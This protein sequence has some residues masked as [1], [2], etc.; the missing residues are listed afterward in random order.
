[1]ASPGTPD[2]IPNDDPPGSPGEEPGIPDVPGDPIPGMGGFDGNNSLFSN[3]QPFPTTLALQ[4][5]LFILKFDFIDEDMA[6]E[7]YEQAMRY[8]H[9]KINDCMQK[10]AIQLVNLKIL[11]DTKLTVGDPRERHDWQNKLTIVQ[12]ATLIVQYFCP[13]G[14]GD[15]TLAESFSKIP[16]HYRL[17]DHDLENATFMRHIDLVSNYERAKGPLT[18]AQH[19]ELIQIFEKRLGKGSQIQQDYFKAKALF[20]P[21]PHTWMKAMLR[22]GEVLNTARQMFATIKSYGNP[23]VPY[24]HPYGS[25]PPELKGKSK[26]K[27]TVASVSSASSTAMVRDPSTYSAVPQVHSKGLGI[28]EPAPVP[29]VPLVRNCRSCGEEGHLLNDCPV[30][31]YNDT[32]NDHNVEWVDSTVGRKWAAVGFSTWQEPFI[33]PGYETR[34]Q[35]YAPGSKPFL[36]CNSNKRVPNSHGSTSDSTSADQGQGYQGKHGQ[37]NQNQGKGVKFAK[38]KTNPGRGGLRFNHPQGKYDPPTNQGE[39]LVP[40]DV[41]YTFDVDSS[42]DV[43]SFIPIREEFLHNPS[44]LPSTHLNVTVIVQDKDKEGPAKELRAVGKAVLDTAN[45]SEDFISFSMLEKLNAMHCCYPALKAITV[46]S[47]LD[48]QCYIN[49]EIV[50]LQ[51]KFHSYDGECH[52]ISLPM[53]VNRQTE[54]DILFSRKTVNK[55]DFWSLT[56]FAFG[57]SPELS[58]EN[59]RKSDARRRE[60]DKKEAL[61]KLDPFH[62]HKYTRRMIAESYKET[63]TVFEHAES[64]TPHYDQLKYPHGKTPCNKRDRGSNSQPN[65]KS[66]LDDQSSKKTNVSCVHTM[67]TDDVTQ[68]V[69]EGVAT[70]HSCGDVSCER[71]NSV[72]TIL[73][74]RTG[75][76]PHL[77][78]DPIPTL[79]HTSEEAVA[80]DYVTQPLWPSGV[81]LSVDEINDDKT[82]TFAPFLRDKSKQSDSPKGPEDFL[83]EI[84]FEGSASFQRKCRELCLELKEI[85]SDEIAEK[86]ASLTP[87]RIDI[88]KEEWEAPENCECVRPQTAPKM[89]ALEGNINEMLASGVLERSDAAYYSHPVMVTKSPGVYRTCIDYRKLNK[90][91]MKKAFPIP[92]IKILFERI[93]HK[94]PDIFGVMDLTAGY[95]QA[96]LYAPHRIF[97]A[98]I[99]FAGVFQF[100]RLPFGPCRA[101]SYFQEQMVTVVLYG[102]IYKCCE[103]YLDDCIV[104]GRGEA[105]F[106]KNLRDVFERFRLKGLRLKAKKCRFGLKRIEYV[107]RVVDQNGLSMSAE[108]IQSVLNFP[109][110][111]NLHLLRS[112]LGLANYFRQFVPMHSILVQPMLDMIDHTA[113][114]RS[115]IVWTQ[116]ST[117]SFLD[118][119]IA[120]S[121]CPLMHFTDEAK[122]DIRLYTDA[123]NF[124]IGG[125]LFQVVGLEW[126]PVAFISKSLSA[127]QI[128]WSTIQKEAYAIFFCCTQLDYLIRDRTFTI[129]TDHLNI[130]YM[131]QNP[132]SMVARW[133]IAMQELDFSVVFVKG[134]SNVLA[135][136]LSR[137]CPNLEEIALP[138]RIQSDGLTSSSSSSFVSALTVIEPPTDEQ[139][140][141]ITMCHNAKVGHNGVDRTLTRLFSLDQVWKNMKQ[142][143][144]SFIRNC[145]CCQKLSAKDPKIHASHFATS[146]YSLFDTLNVDFVGPFPDKGYILVMIDTFSRW[147]E[148][149]WCKDA[150]A[151]TAAAC[152]L[153]HFGRFGS[154]N[155]IRSDRGSHFAN[156]LIKDFL[157]LTGTPHNLTLAY[158]SQENAIVERVNKE[159]NRYLRG[160][161]FDKQTME[162]YAESIP[163]VQRIINSSVN[164]ST[165][166]S[167]AHM[168]FGNKLDLNRGILT[169]HLSVG[170]NSRSTYVSDL[171][172]TQDMVLDAAIKSLLKSNDKNTSS[173]KSVTV[174]P[175]GTYVLSRYSDRPPTRLH[176]KWHGPYRVVSFKDSEYVLANLITHKERSTHIKNLKVF[177]YDPSIGVPA[178]TARRDYMEYF[179]E[180]ILAHSGDT[181]KPT[182]MSFHVKWLNYDDS[183]N[184]WEPWKQLRLVEALHD[185]LRENKM[186]HFIPKN[187]EETA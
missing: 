58:A 27:S 80:D 64:L 45:Y 39:D 8:P 60:F 72:T 174:F 137:L 161:V 136:A 44:T 37:G 129:Y 17:S 41:S 102:L 4:G 94:K 91:L 107:G 164:K 106:L 160:L 133:F 81:A 126:Q 105:E 92:N 166:F 90:H 172:D 120:V 3:Q 176:T 22:L 163:F 175:I 49:N 86:P 18:V 11:C 16:F 10:Q 111:K 59:K 74:K 125:V 138:F 181:K 20:N 118:T 145:A 63:P 127:T 23:E 88:P 146:N 148:M 117:N 165:G 15:S 83:K 109:V 141:Y 28:R 12:I 183:H 54:I 103:M 132:T 50:D 135:D 156:D 154:P 116:E 77:G 140:E 70:Q 158:S 7:F 43:P 95:H 162:G 130:T 110:P 26:G 79:T 36:M 178:D 57:I 97:T 56:P 61:D 65:K 121:R 35:Y 184:T 187:L 85:F 84:T 150:T 169:P 134:S 152:L 87:F 182:T 100:T 113:A 167:P 25:V 73:A 82:D 171:L 31:Y 149:F 119:K 153:S 21:A 30:L 155:M 66:K 24:N 96:P 62:Q 13:N 112:F 78:E 51:I 143:V 33:L 42:V 67:S 69:L 177:N 144:R 9:L 14:L 99:C 40:D 170:T 168:L 131:K 108:K 47:G 1:M 2:D 186:K 98:F 115:A 123:S 159:V 55:Y 29:V 139:I 89:V 48:G 142:H 68:E 6:I 75:D 5:E 147:T 76:T 173:S 52:S 122:S 179:V 101:P 71:M 38:N 114:K 34:V 151:P 93:G 185:Y 124:G 46:C 104:Y 19:H 157:D 32:N 180:K 53:R 128:N